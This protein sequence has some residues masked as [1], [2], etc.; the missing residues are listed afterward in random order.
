M[1]ENLNRR[2]IAKYPKGGQSS[3]IVL[4]WRAQEQAGISDGERIPDLVKAAIE[5]RLPYGWEWFA[6]PIPPYLRPNRDRQMGH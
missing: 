3:I 4:L 2:E 1:V 5:G 6:S